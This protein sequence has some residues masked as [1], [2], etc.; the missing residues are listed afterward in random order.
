MNCS[1]AMLSV[2]LLMFLSHCNF[3][4]WQCIYCVYTS[5]INKY[6][7]VWI[8]HTLKE[9]R[10]LDKDRKCILKLRICYLSGRVC[11]CLTAIEV[12]VKWHWRQTVSSLPL[13]KVGPFSFPQTILFPSDKTPQG[14]ELE[15]GHCAL[16]V[17]FTRL[18]TQCNTAETK[19]K[20]E[21]NRN[22][23]M[24]WDGRKHSHR[25]PETLCPLLGRVKPQFFLFLYINILLQKRFFLMHKAVM[26]D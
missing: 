2:Y 24:K 14:H 23:V 18:K 26:K 12:N 9:K 19:R 11:K 1:E 25:T 6:V 4:F 13:V 16:H 21:V 22:S 5:Y 15:L 10:C 8:I 17:S 20:K 7:N 3:F